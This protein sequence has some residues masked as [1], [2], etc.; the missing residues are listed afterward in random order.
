VR[1]TEERKLIAP[2]ESAER[3]SRRRPSISS[4]RR[5]LSRIRNPSATAEENQGSPKLRSERSQETSTV[6]G[7]PSD[8]EGTPNGRRSFSLRRRSL[9][10]GPKTS[11][12]AQNNSEKSTSGPQQSQGAILLKENL[13]D[14][15]KTHRRRWS[16]T[17]WRRSPSQKAS[18]PASPG[19]SVN[20]NEIKDSGNPTPLLAYSP[21]LQVAPRDSY[22]GGSTHLRGSSRT[23]SSP[24]DE[25]APYRTVSAGAAVTT[26]KQSNRHTITDTRGGVWNL[27]QTISRGSMA[28]VKMALNLETGERV[29]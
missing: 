8:V 5:S 3:R 12:A 13:S 6:R 9:S 4:I 16:F 7:N 11:A 18:T 24:A 22:P 21:T 10:L 29:L 17:F 15:E 2:M 27:K 28:K 19:T 23:R 20:H 26:T 1:H 14:V 25:P